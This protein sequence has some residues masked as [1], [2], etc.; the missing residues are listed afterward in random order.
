MSQELKY[1]QYT[2]LKKKSA[3]NTPGTPEYNQRIR[4]KMRLYTQGVIPHDSN[5]EKALRQKW[6]NENFRSRLNNRV[7]KTFENNKSYNFNLNNANNNYPNNFNKNNNDS[8][9]EEIENHSNKSRRSRKSR[10]KSR[11]NGSRKN[12]RG[13]RR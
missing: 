11:R 5:E 2:N 7:T 3:Y 10:R 1:P 6:L 12:T 9:A 4:E 8:V 13:R